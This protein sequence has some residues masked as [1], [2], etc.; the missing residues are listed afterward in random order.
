MTSII[1]SMIDAADLRCTV[2]RTSAKV[3]C[4]CWTRCGCGWS[5]RKGGT[6][7]NPACPRSDVVTMRCP[8]CQATKIVG[9]DESDPPNAITVVFPC[10]KC[11][12]KPGPD[13]IYLDSQS[14]AVRGLR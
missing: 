6:C 7:S 5:F 11:Q 4:D 8:T 3:G 12:T 9:R 13:P 1:A 10:P 14:H 2:C